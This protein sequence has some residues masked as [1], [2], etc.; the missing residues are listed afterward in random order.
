MWC[1]RA[2]RPAGREAARVRD[3]RANPHRS[4]RLRGGVQCLPLIGPSDPSLPTNRHNPAGVPRSNRQGETCSKDDERWDRRVCPLA[5]RRHPPAGRPP[6]PAPQGG[7]QPIATARLSTPGCSPFG[8]SLR[9]AL[10]CSSS[11]SNDPARLIRR[12]PPAERR[13]PPHPR[14]PARP[15]RSPRRPRPRRVSPSSAPTSGVTRCRAHTARCLLFLPCFTLPTALS[16]KSDKTKYVTYAPGHPGCYTIDSAV[17]NRPPLLRIHS[18]FRRFA[19]S[20]SPLA[21]NGS[22]LGGSLLAFRCYVSAVCCYISGPFVTYQPTSPFISLRS[23]PP[24]DAT[25]LRMQRLQRNPEPR[26][27]NRLRPLRSLPAFRLLLYLSHGPSRRLT[28]SHESPRA[29]SLSKEWTENAKWLAP[30]AKVLRIADHIFTN[31]RWAGR[32]L[33]PRKSL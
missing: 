33:P 14:L 2:V 25:I 22:A 6:P 30:S 28:S 24:R 16:L 5:H 13:T 8:L 1:W 4:R 9:F 26:I 7:K 12:D 20:R 10:G 19:P 27:T 17:T 15:S 32:A 3:C 21:T 29:T 18:V 23:A 11:D 31:D